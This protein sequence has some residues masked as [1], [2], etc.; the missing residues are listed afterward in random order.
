MT[1]RPLIFVTVGTD[2]HPFERLVRWTEGL[3]ERHPEADVVLQ[4]GT[5]RPAR[6]ARNFEMMGA[7]DFNEHLDE[8]ALVIAQGGPGGIFEARAHGKLPLVVPRSGD[9]G[10]HV[11]NHQQ[12]FAALLD[13]RGLV[14][15]VHEE[16]AFTDAVDRMLAD[17]SGRI[18]PDRGHGADVERALR[19]VV[20]TLRPLPWR[21]KLRRAW[22]SARPVPPPP[23]P[24]RRFGP[25]T[26]SA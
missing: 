2:V 10:E 6:G 3:V 18:P 13:G 25:R 20:A 16:D 23:E 19:E 22:S 17:G 5:S 4:H 15:V 1:E 14:R 11:D 8:C 26:A 7:E 21:T 24:D 12:L 9:L